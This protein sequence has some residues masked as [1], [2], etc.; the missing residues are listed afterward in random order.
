LCQTFNSD[1]FCEGCDVRANSLQSLFA[2][3][4]SRLLQFKDDG[5]MATVVVDDVENA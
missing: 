5:F 4:E 3:L 2:Q 1:V